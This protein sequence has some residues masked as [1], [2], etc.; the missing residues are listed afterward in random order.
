MLRRQ[1][2]AH[3][4]KTKGLVEMVAVS[5]EDAIMQIKDQG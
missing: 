3:Q 2:A 1:A 5:G 4:P